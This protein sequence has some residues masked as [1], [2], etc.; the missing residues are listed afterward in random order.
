MATQA[1]SSVADVRHIRIEQ[2]SR[3]SV[4]MIDCNIPSVRIVL[5]PIV[6]HASSL[7]SVATPIAA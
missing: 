4:W 6:A 3:I 7:V 1:G 2:I 5:R